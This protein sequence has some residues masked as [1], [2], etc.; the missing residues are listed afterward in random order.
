MTLLVCSIWVDDASSLGRQ[1]DQ[2][3]ADGAEA[4]ELRLDTFDGEPADLADYLRRHPQ[5]TWI[6]TCRSAEEG[7]HFRGD[8][9]ER[10]S[11]LLAAARGTN[12]FIDFE[13]ADWRRSSNIR[14][15][16]LLAAAPTDTAG[17]NAT[18][19]SAAETD[20]PAGPSGARTVAP[21]LILSA[22][23]LA[24]VP[25][26][27]MGLAERMQ[28]EPVRAA[29]LAYAADDAFDA[30]PALDLVHAHGFR[31]CVIAMG[32]AGACTRVLARKLGAFAG[33]AALEADAPT[34]PGQLCL[35]DMIGLYR[36]PAIDTGTQVYGLVG[37]PVAHS[38]S[39]LLFNRWFGR[40]GRN[41]VYLPFRVPG[42]A[43]SLA[44][45]LDALRHRPWLDVGGLSVTLPHKAAALEYAGSGADRAAAGAGA[46]NTLVFR[47]GEV[48]G[49]NTDRHAAV[50]SLVAALG[51]DRRDLAGL[52]VDVLG[53]GGAARAVIA[54]LTDFGARITVFARSPGSAA[55]L[56]E[57]FACRAEPWEHRAR[58][59]GQ[60]LINST[61]VGMW[62]R[63]EASPLPD[64]A[65]AG[66]RLVFDLVYAPLQTRLLRDAAGAGAHT[67]N[68][69]DMLLR[70]AAMQYALWT[71][72]RPETSG[73][74]ELVTAEVR[75]RT[76]E[77]ADGAPSARGRRAI[78]LIGARGCGKTI[79]GRELASLLGGRSIDTDELV[80]TRAG[81]PIAAIFAQDGEPV[82]RQMEREA[83]E[84]VVLDPPAVISVGGGAVLDEENLKRLRTVARLVWL[85]A[86]AA[87]LRARL[88]AD[89]ASREHR[90]SLTPLTPE[91]EVEVLLG[92]RAAAYERAADL[93][94]STEG[95]S[96]AAIA[97]K[98]VRQIASIPG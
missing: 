60:V 85:T 97:R 49:F 76:G 30:L 33:Y 18:V 47:K 94:V 10:V 75:R 96:P 58:R 4:V 84:A 39:P 6:V 57:T 52:P 87:V 46:A 37:D 53:A 66:C 54:G 68:G 89:A 27:A 13:Y 78:A 92:E 40:A 5:R 79:V 7:G 43:G 69:L 35:R 56:A 67:L 71:G 34:A 24:G 17:G 93:I 83:I 29:K 73:D 26:D 81:R 62:P 70:Q 3:W 38:V 44:R 21:R 61:S 95:L 11:R 22:H 72:D 1:A 23:V 90:P 55:A 74:S 88:D 91:R 48:R 41:A 8:T 65:L 31:V 77:A 50:D 42:G 86:P 36:W 25:A 14:Q 64:H 28:R 98:I 2:A 12:A 16:V 80:T 20:A 82:F 19:A 32:E 51:G 59:A 63:V 9:A 15:K 45:F